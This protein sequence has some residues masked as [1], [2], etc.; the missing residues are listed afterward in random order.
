MGFVY[1]IFRIPLAVLPF[2]SAHAHYYIIGFG[3]KNK[4][5]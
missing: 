5:L 4:I 3:R 1:S 2:A